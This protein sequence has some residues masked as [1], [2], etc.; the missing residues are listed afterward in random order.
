MTTDRKQYDVAIAGAGPAGSSLAIRLANAGL[1]VILTEQKA[2]PREKLCGAFISPECQIHFNE[3]GVL[4][5]I[6]AAGGTELKETVFFAQSGKGV[7]V[8]SAWFGVPDS[9]ALGLSR[10]EMDLI[11]FSRAKAVGVDVRGETS[12]SGHVSR[13]ACRW[14]HASRQKR[15]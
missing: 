3:L 15:Y 8:E 9:L 13:W 7:A 11:L 10:A 4:P 1:S 6:K 5:H 2:F 12:V 14:R